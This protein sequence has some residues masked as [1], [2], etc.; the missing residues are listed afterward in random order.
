[1]IMSTI[2]NSLQKGMIPLPKSKRPKTKSV[3]VELASQVGK[4]EFVETT[5]HGDE[6]RDLVLHISIT[7]IFRVAM[8]AVLVQVT[9]LYSHP[10][11]RCG[12]IR[13]SRIAHVRIQFSAVEVLLRLQ[14]VVYNW[15]PVLTAIWALK[16][17]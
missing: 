6:M 14:V 7:M 13:C 5:P 1:M 3:A 2:F 10:F 8:Q 15:I 11:N 4:A 9:Y 16:F 17:T 12:V